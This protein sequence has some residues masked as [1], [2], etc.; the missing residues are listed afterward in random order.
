MRKAAEGAGAAPRITDLF[1]GAS[2]VEYHRGTQWIPD[3]QTSLARGDRESS[4]VLA[5]TH[6]ASRSRYTDRFTGDYQFDPAI[7]LATP[8]VVVRRDRRCVAKTFGAY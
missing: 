7:A 5:E 4:L 2:L 6:C 8:G 1:C 3:L